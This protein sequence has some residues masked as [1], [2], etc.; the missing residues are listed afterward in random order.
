MYFGSYYGAIGISV[1]LLASF[2]ASM[3][4]TWRM[5]KKTL[6]LKMKSSHNSFMLIFGLMAVSFLITQVYH[7]NFISKAIIFIVFGLYISVNALK[8]FGGISTLWFR[9]FELWLDFEL[10]GNATYL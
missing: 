10:I 3:V 9:T 4:F 2:I 8:Q 6:Q 5:F 1:A 7:L